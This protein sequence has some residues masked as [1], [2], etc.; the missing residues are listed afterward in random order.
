MQF[1]ESVSAT[2]EAA[3]ESA[4]GVVVTRD[5]STHRPG[6]QTGLWSGV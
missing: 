1:I 6:Q 2:G 3:E 5:K 4:R